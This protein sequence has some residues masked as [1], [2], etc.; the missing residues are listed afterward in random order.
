MAHLERLV[1]SPIVPRL[2]LAE[3]IRI[4]DTCGGDVVVHPD[5]GFRTLPRASRRLLT[6]H[7][8]GMVW[9]T[10][11]DQLAVPFYQATDGGA[12]ALTA[13]LLVAGD[14]MVRAGQ[15]HNTGEAVLDALERR[16]MSPGRFEWYARMKDDDPVTTSGFSFDIGG[17]Q[18]YV[19]QQDVPDPR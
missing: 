1:A 9:L 14:T 7:C 12:T 15:R 3:A 5:R 10:H 6:E 11:A 8:G 4:L 17:F 16:D 2:S 13:D 19:L 18:R